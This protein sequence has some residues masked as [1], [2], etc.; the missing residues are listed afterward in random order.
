MSNDLTNLVKVHYQESIQENLEKNL[1]AMD[2]AGMIDIPNG[3]TKNLP[4]IKPSAVGEYVKYSSN[5]AQDVLTGNDQI[6]INKTPYILFALDRID[7]DEDYIK[8]EPELISDASYQIKRQIDGEFFAQ[9]ANAK[10]KYD[11]NGF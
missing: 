2:L 10:W 7:M 6:V 11:A 9:V 4:Y 3:T 5:T 1:T 8:A